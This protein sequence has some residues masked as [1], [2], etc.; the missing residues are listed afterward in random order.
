MSR[1]MLALISVVAGLSL[2][3][4]YADDQPT[5]KIE[6]NQTQWSQLSAEEKSQVEQALSQS[7]PGQRFA[8]APAS[9]AA[10]AAI[11]KADSSAMQAR[12][13]SRR[14]GG[15]RGVPI[16]AAASGRNLSCRSAGVAEDLRWRLRQEP[17]A[18]RSAPS[19]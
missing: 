4:A 19:R 18:G 5:P 7:F 8:L 1:L 16:A 14:C 3:T 10:V 9:G 12:L 13:P 2:A 6:V 15:G 17:L 11:P